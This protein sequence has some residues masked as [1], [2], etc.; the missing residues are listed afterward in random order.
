[1]KNLI[2]IIF[3]IPFTLVAA[4]DVRQFTPYYWTYL[5]EKD[6]SLSMKN[7]PL[8]VHFKCDTVLADGGHSR[9]Y[10]SDFSCYGHSPNKWSYVR[11]PDGV[12]LLLPCFAEYHYPTGMKP[13]LYNLIPDL[14][15]VVGTN[16]DGDPIVETKHYYASWEEQETKPEPEP[17]EEPEPKTTSNSNPCTLQVGGKTIPL[18]GTVEVV[19]SGAD[20]KI[21]IVSSGADLKVERV[22][23]GAIYCGKW[24]FVSSG[25]DFKVEIVSS[26]ADLKVEFV[27][28]GA[29]MR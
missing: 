1:M 23:S 19:S 7:S 18:Y 25:A 10:L 12:K 11:L 2:F 26:G 17:K 3:I 21:E 15:K 29:G 8:R 14:V 28:S 20:F 5:V 24:E 22:S 6:G 16:E 4:Q 9:I 13:G 27:T